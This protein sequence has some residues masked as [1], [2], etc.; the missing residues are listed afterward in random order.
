MNFS[1]YNPNDRYRKRSAKRAS[2]IIIFSFLFLIV[3]A[4]GYWLG[5]MRSQ[6]NTYILQEEKRLLNEE[7]NNLKSDI[8]K[9]RAETQTANVRLE[10]LKASYDELLSDGLISDIVTLV[11]KQIDQGVDA[12]RLKSVILSARPPQ[13]CSD[14]ENKRFVIITP[15]YKGPNSIASINRGA[16]SI[17][18]KGISSKNSKGK[19][20]AW[21]DPS[22]PVSIMF[23]AKGKDIEVKKGLLPLHHSMVLGDKEYRFTITSAAKSF[24]KVTF[25]YCDYP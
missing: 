24:V 6:Q 2:N 14:P 10:Q 18:G 16:I 21:F 19:K 20:E 12:Q 23:K 25:D 22:Q 8:V 5:N 13:N 17:F 7:N 11:K 3:F 1:S 4:L 9:M 15:V